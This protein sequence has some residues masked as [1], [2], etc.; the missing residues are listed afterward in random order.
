MAYD[1]PSRAWVT[2]LAGAILTIATV[3]SAL[4]FAFW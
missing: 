2:P 4:A 1:M 3:G